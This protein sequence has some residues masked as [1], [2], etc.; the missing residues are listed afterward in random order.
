[1]KRQIKLNIKR[2]LLSKLVLL[3]ALFLGSSNAWGNAIDNGDGT[4]TENFVGY[5]RAFK[6]SSYVIT[7]PTG[8]YASPSGVPYSY[9]VPATSTGSYHTTS[10]A[11]L[12]S[13]SNN[14]SYYII[15]PVITGNFKLWAKRYGSGSPSV[16]AY[17]CTY[18]EL[19]ESFTCGSLIKS[20][21][22]TADYAEYEFE[23]SGTQTRVAL[24]INYAY[25]DDFTYTPYVAVGD[26]PVPTS[27]ST[28]NPQSTSIDLNWT[29]GGSETT[30]QFSYGTTSGSLEH[31]SGYV[32]T[33]PYTLT[34][35]TPN[36]TYYIS[37]RALNEVFSEWSAE[38][39]FT[40]I[41]DIPVTSVTVSPTSWEMIAGATKPLT[42]TVLPNDAT[43]KTVSWESNN[44][45]VATVSSEGVVTAVAPGLATITVKST[46]DG[47]KAATCEITVTAPI[48]PT[49]FKTSDLTSNYTRLTWTNGSSETKWQIK[50]GTTSGS[51]DKVSGDITS[52]PYLITCLNPNTTY[53]ASIRSKLGT[54]YSAWS[55]ELSFTTESVG[56]AAGG[57]VETTEDFESGWPVNNSNY[58]TGVKSGW[59][60]I[61][62]YSG[63]KIDTTNKYEGNYGLSAGYNSSQYLIFPEVKVGSTIKL[64]AKRTLSS[65]TIKIHRVIKV[66]NSYYLD[67]NTNYFEGS[68]TDS[69]S[70][71]TSNVIT[72]GGYVAINV[73]NAAI[74][75]IT[76]QALSTVSA[77]T[78][79]NGFATFASTSEM[80]LTKGNL[81]D[82]LIA[83]KA[84]VNASKGIISFTDIDQS[85]SAL[86][87]VLL[88]GNPHTEYK[89]AIADAGSTVDGND[90]EVNSTG[91]T[92]APESGYTYFG[93]KKNSDPITF[94]TFNPSTVAIPT[95]KAYLKVETSLLPPAEARQLVAVFDDGE[96]TGIT[97]VRGLKS[98][99]RGEFFNLNGQRVA[100]PTKGLYIVNGKK[101]LVP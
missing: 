42:A 58:L 38:T 73:Y 77:V 78:D 33:N 91:Y 31:K 74:D 24:L 18:D 88:K 21:T 95:N 52:K 57:A 43:Y 17:K 34:G 65:G 51:L 83:Y 81:P 67:D 61:S 46:V 56:P 20:I 50:Y 6:N 98:E 36:T 14:T 25:L 32:T 93:F 5:S 37:I 71:Y 48:I 11:I 82:G 96:T 2:G 85:V 76:Y 64:W 13:A 70:N 100:Q 75:N 27:L 49:C 30:W 89:I 79:D 68:L 47:T 40:T 59:G 29:A 12:T 72:E 90:F 9:N 16:T 15:T 35:L 19:S 84:M 45:S 92:F 80:D 63:F 3:V 54:A 10:P 87:G 69:W 4:F 7:T 8:W 39:S 22:P 97:E 94:A 86:T 53:Y 41:G 66:G 28:S 101:V 1:M 23:Y 99:G 26:I 55:D 60:Y 62:N 44:T